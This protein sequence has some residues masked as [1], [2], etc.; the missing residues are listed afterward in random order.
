[1]KTQY[2]IVIEHGETSWGGYVPDLP[3]VGVVGESEAEVR[4]LLKE[5]VE[6]H[7]QG[8]EEDGVVIP[9]PVSK[10]EYIELARTA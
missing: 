1:M 3:G 9:K 4:H 10:V 6:L 8:L 2:A 5:A 7:L